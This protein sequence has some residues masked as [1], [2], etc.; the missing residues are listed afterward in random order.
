[1]LIADAFLWLQSMVS[2]LRGRLSTAERDLEAAQ[3]EARAAQQECDALA[4]QLQLVRVGESNIKEAKVRC[5]FMTGHLC[6]PAVC[7]RQRR[8]TGV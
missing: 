3:R 1:M 4:S 6:I 2:D 8:E 5:G 7:H